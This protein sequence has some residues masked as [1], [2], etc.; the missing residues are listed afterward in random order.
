MK[1]PPDRVAFF[2][3]FLQIGIVGAAE[4]IIDAYVVKVGQPN[5]CFGGRYTLSVFKFG[6]QGLFNAGFHLHGDLRVPLVLAQKF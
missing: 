2:V 1:K 5:Q 3:L 4:N 6:Q